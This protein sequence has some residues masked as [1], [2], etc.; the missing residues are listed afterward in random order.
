MSLF[1]SALPVEE[2]TQGRPLADRMRPRTLDEFMGQEHLLGPGKPLRVQ[3]ERDQLSSML[4]WGPPGVGKT[5]LARLIARAGRSEF[6]SFSAVLSSIK[7]VKAVMADAR[8]A[9]KSGM[10]TLVFVDE[11]H[12]FNKAQQDAFLPYVERG[13]VI[14]IGATTENP[15]F[16][17]ISAL[18]SRCQVHILRALTIEELVGILKAALQDQ[19]RGLGSA[20]VSASND[21][22]KRIALFSNGDARAA[23]KTLES[24]V[25]SAPDNAITEELLAAVLERKLV[26]YDKSGEE[27]FNLVSALHKSIRSSD[28]DAALYWLDRM[29][30]GGEDRIYILRRL[31]RMSFEDIGLADPRALEQAVAALEAF[32]LIGEPEGDL[33]LAQLTVYLAMAPKS[34]AV[35]RALSSVKQDVQNTVAEPVPMQLR[36][37]STRAM[38]QW[39]Y[40]EG[41]QH[42]HQFEDAVTNM[43]CLPESL[44]GRRYYHPT[45]RGVEKRISERLRELLRDKGRE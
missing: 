15:S 36:N 32:R 18:L 6:V 21:L 2:E 1:E 16:E 25:A 7:D 8:R 17:V 11:I 26:R 23:L 4:L 3:I 38:K 10:R 13:D 24:A 28:P 20:G 37:A 44:K 12:R 5:T 35:Y 27:H 29:L 39:G 14:L 43:E 22:L 9:H 42:A 41:Y 31:V 45:E 19:E 34:D 30:E 33:V 40:G